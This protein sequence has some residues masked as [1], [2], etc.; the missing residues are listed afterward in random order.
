MPPPPPPDRRRGGG[1]RGASRSPPKI[2][3]GDPLVKNQKI[4]FNNVLTL[5]ST[6]TII[7]QYDYPVFIHQLAKKNFFTFHQRVPPVE[8]GRRSGGASFASASASGGGAEAEAREALPRHTDVSHIV[9][10][11]FNF[12]D[13]PSADS[14]L[15][16]N[17]FF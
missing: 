11:V 12:F 5:P 10:V 13:E 1:E 9:Y 2:N 16:F 15:F 8:F 6:H 14:F 3:R 17:C 4:F 7:K